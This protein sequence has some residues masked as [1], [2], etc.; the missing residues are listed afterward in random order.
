MRW[1]IKV[2]ESNKRHRR[3]LLNIGA[4]CFWC[5]TKVD[6]NNSSIDHLIPRCITDNNCFYNKVL[7]CLKCNN[8]RS[9]L[10]RVFKFYKIRAK[11]Q[12]SPHY[13]VD[14]HERYMA[15]HNDNRFNHLVLQS[16]EQY[17]E[18]VRL[19]IARLIKVF[20]VTSRRE[21]ISK[22]ALSDRN[23]SLTERYE[24]CFSN[25]KTDSV[26]NYKDVV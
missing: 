12:R 14:E 7:S 17:K 4:R 5:L 1:S 24:H 11:L 9:N 16:I 8:E 20:N 6:D 19:S 18:S 22:Y 26:Y 23:R 25:L 13:V 3:L 10:Q 2:S 21:F 15:T